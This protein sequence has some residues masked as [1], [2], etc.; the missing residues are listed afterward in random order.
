M[1]LPLNPRL[2]IFP[3]E[4]RCGRRLL[5]NQARHTVA[6]ISATLSF[7][8]RLIVAAGPLLPEVARALIL[9]GRSLLLDACLD[10][11]AHSL[12]YLRHSKHARQNGE[13][14]DAN[15]CDDNCCKVVMVYGDLALR[16]CVYGELHLCLLV[17][18]HAVEVAEEHIAEDEQLSIAD[19]V[20]CLNYTKDA[21]AGKLGI[22]IRRI[23]QVGRWHHLKHCRADLENDRF[24][25][26][27]D[28]V[29]VLFC[30]AD[31]KRTV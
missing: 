30:N 8:S 11:P 21:A 10:A 7:L 23:D 5:R 12:S 14:H 27:L 20:R 18:V 6:R 28:L 1:P 17:V 29:T 13:G 22:N 19:D 9:L 31:A 25:V 16:M 24:Q 26:R 3:L 4:R 2:T 15:V